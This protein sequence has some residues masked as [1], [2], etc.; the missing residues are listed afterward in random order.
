MTNFLVKLFIKNSENTSDPEVREKYGTLSG[1]VGIALNL[2]LAGAKFIIGTFVAHSIAISADALNNFSDAASSLL[3]VIGFRIAGKE[4]DPE[5]PFGH[6]RFE[7]I[8]ALA[9]GVLVELMGFEL[10]R[11]SVDKIRSPEP[12]S[13]SYAAAVVLL[14]SIG[15]KI[16]LALFN[17][18]LGKKINSPA[19]SAVVADSISDSTATGV[20]LI[21]L[22]AS[23]FTSANIDGW[24]GIIVAGFI[25]YS[26]F[27]ILKETVGILLGAPPEDE[28]VKDVTRYILSHDKVMGI[29]DLVVHSYGANSIFA[30]IHVEFSAD[31][32]M[33]LT[34]DL[35]DCM[36]Q[37][38]LNNFGVH[39]TMHLDPLV[40][41]D[42]RINELRAK[43]KS[44]IK[45]MDESFEFHDFRVVDGPTHTNLIFDLVIPHKYPKTPEE[46]KTEVMRKI[47]E[48]SE[49]CFAVVT[50]EYNYV[51]K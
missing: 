14:L 39:M 42:S 31:D 47:K 15:G 23:E 17:R 35:I 21:A 10:V 30:S 49:T 4:A 1:G 11:S 8:T 37:E 16:W 22:I 32:D 36:E 28:L 44:V 6:G 9:V 7:Y 46:I 3:T 50:V 24:A 33:V 29:H 13:F 5:H 20:A 40:F 48:V 12:V 34:H 27:G 2:I 38:I 18:K 26:G 41:N 43:T 19:M 25:L 45:D 51:R